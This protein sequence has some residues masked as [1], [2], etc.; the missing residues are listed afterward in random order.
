MKSLAK[1]AVLLALAVYSPAL[2]DSDP[3]LN[4]LAKDIVEATASEDRTGFDKHYEP[5]LAEKI[6]TANDGP[7]GAA[8]DFD[9]MTNSQDPDYAEIEKSIQSKVTEES[10]TAAVIEVTFEQS[11]NEAV[12]EYHA[13][14]AGSDWLIHDIVYPNGDF[15]LRKTLGMQ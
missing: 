8:L 11:D 7:D 2:A 10:D 4:E 1:L 9:Y 15:G 12:I 3:A 14:K 13:R 6:D 5:D